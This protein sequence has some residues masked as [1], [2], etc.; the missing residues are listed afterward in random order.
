M[1]EN[2]AKLLQASK[3]IEGGKLVRIKLKA[4]EFIND[5]Q[6]SGD[7]FLHPEDAIL[8]IEQNLRALHIDTDAEEIEARIEAALAKTK[9]VFVG[10][11]SQEL[12]AL[13]S[14]ALSG[15]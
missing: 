6:I 15:T 11:N 7:F 13:I 14:Q 4:G 2:S 3:K 8:E 1:E 12:A 10:V 9:G 5:I